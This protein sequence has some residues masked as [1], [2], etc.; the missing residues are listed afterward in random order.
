MPTA[1]LKWT[2]KVKS[3]KRSHPTKHTNRLSISIQT[4]S[5][6]L[7]EV[8]D[9]MIQDVEGTAAQ[10]DDIIVQGSSVNECKERL[11]TEYEAL[12]LV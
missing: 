12:I 10:F 2:K 6:E 4:V 3:Y 11:I 5:Y 7:K 9:N 8:M 1:I